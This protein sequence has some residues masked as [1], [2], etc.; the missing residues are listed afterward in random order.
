MTPRTQ[1]I[2]LRILAAGMFTSMS[3]C[4]RFVVQEIP[5]GQVIFWRSFIALFP[6]LAYIAWHDGLRL[7]L[8]TKRP[9]LHVTRSCVGGVSMILS[10]TAL[11]Y[12]PV[13]TFSALSY[14][15]PMITLPIAAYKLRERLSLRL[16][17]ACLMGFAGVMAILSKTFLGP[18][19]DIDSLK[20]IAAGISFAISIA[21]MRVHIKEMT[22]T[23]VPASIAFYFTVFTTLL[24][25]A[26]WILGWEPLT[27][28]LLLPLIAAG[29]LGGMAHVLTSEAAARTEVSTLAPYD[30][31]GMIFALG[32][33]ILIFQFVPSV[34]S[35]IGVFVITAAGLMIAFE[36]PR[37]ARPAMLN[38]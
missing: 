26:S 11:S 36:A 1:G 19:F 35:L 9:M 33:D 34:W 38:R 7:A 28:R 10:F 18:S 24:G 8:H 16:T 17:V 31:T 12:L 20:G 21:I 30:Y 22:R 15:A 6:I 37:K 2:L 5:I 23:E 25:A 3:A 29:F 27:M 4:V 14:M 32:I 13:S